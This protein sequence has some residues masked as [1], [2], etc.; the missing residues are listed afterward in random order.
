MPPLPK[1]ILLRGLPLLAGLLLLVVMVIALFGIR[2]ETDIIQTLPRG[3]AVM[4]DGA[5]VLLNHPYQNR[6][7][8]D[9]HLE[10]NN[11]DMLVEAAEFVKAE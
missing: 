4:A 10:Q 3:N 7:F 1:Q 2:F 6:V 11:P 9:M 5:Y 8:I